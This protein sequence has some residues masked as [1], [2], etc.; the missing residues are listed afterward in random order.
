MLE[1]C[2]GDK[3]KALAKLL[4]EQLASI[5]TLKIHMSSFSNLPALGDGQPL[6]PQN[7]AASFSVHLPSQDRPIEIAQPRYGLFSAS[8][9]APLHR[10]PPLFA[11]R[12]KAQR[13]G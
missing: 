10:G 2:G 11:G 9:V 6:Q 3:E 8:E 5:E 1:E 13:V 7:Y 12:G 4:D